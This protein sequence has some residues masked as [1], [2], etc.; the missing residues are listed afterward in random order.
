MV[1]LLALAILAVP[2]Q[3]ISAAREARANFGHHL[4]LGF[5]H[6]GGSDPRVD[7]AFHALWAAGRGLFVG[8]EFAVSLEQPPACFEEVD[9]GLEPYCGRDTQALRL[10]MRFEFGRTI[11]GRLS[12]GAGPG[13]QEEY[14]DFEG[15][16]KLD[17]PRWV[18]STVARAGFYLEPLTVW[19]AGIQPGLV[20]DAST[21]GLERPVLGFGVGIDCVF[22]D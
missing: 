17:A 7:F 6:T 9:A 19:G 3:N 11:V 14:G 13:Y 10:M 18:L 20:A 2:P 8:G 21:V 22:Y 12:M 15:E 1:A 5:P 16:T 4:A